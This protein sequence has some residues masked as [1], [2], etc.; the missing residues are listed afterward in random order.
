MS[1]PKISVVR[2]NVI[3]G[4]IAIAA[5]GVAAVPASAVAAGQAPAAT[6]RSARPA[7]RCSSLLT[8]SASGPAGRSW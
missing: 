5:L 2:R 4:G 1:M 3:M 7:S 8:R 6:H